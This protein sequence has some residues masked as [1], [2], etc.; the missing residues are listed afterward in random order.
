MLGPVTGPRNRKAQN[1]RVPSSPFYKLPR[2]ATTGR[3]VPVAA[4]VFPPLSCVQRK[5]SALPIA[6]EV[7]D[8]AFNVVPA[9]S[10]TNAIS[11]PKHP[12]AEALNKDS[13]SRHDS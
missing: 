10:W 4:L 7:A 12:L 3:G 8:G 6:R 9:W 2:Q 1:T 5:P 13:V 11:S